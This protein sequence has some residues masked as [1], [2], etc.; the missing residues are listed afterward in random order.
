MPST[1]ATD[2]PRK[3]KVIAW[4]RCS[5]GVSAAMADA[6]CGVK[7][8][9]PSIVRQ[10]SSSSTPK[11]VASALSRWPAAYHSSASTSRRRRSQP[12]SSPA[13]SGEPMAI[14]TA[15]API[16][17]P[18]SAT[19]T[20][21]ERTTSLSTPAEDMMPQPMAKLPASSAQRGAVAVLSAAPSAHPG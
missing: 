11:S 1:E 2:Q 8:A 5:G 4:P 14:T 7:A 13:S 3:M 19:D 6:A 10:R 21:S 17:C 12:L 15:A 18:P 9:A 16:S 20:C